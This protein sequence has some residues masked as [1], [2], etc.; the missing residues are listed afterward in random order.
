VIQI[1]V[2]P[3]SFAPHC[4]APFVGINGMFPDFLQM[5]FVKSDQ[6]GWQGIDGQFV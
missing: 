3:Y 4:V 6:L 1:D 2:M 5:F